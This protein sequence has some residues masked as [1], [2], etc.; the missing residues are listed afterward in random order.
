ML[1]TR[2]ITLCLGWLCLA[3]A[4]LLSAQQSEP[5]A[6][7]AANTFADALPDA[8]V[9]QTALPPSQIA[10]STAT[11]APLPYASLSS[12]TIFTNK[13]A[14]PLLG[15]DKLKYAGVEMI[16]PINLPHALVS[17]EFS[18]FQGGDP[19]YGN[20]FGAYEERFGAAMLRETS[21]RFF[22]DG[23]FP[24]M[25]HED[26]RYYR[27]DNHGTVRQRLLYSM[28]R[29]FVT[30]TDA[31]AAVPNYASLLG[32]AAGA[33]LTLSYYPG[34][35]Q[36][37]GVVLRTFADSIAVQIGLDMVREFAPKLRWLL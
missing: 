22:A 3:I 35:S 11:P 21:Y 19:K 7:T 8:P 2:R 32:H 37:G 10:A 28:T 6:R 36:G 27:M 1:G 5:H 17:A 34:T 18:Q 31:G 13:Q 23:L 15:I 25:L 33:A 26:P 20:D 14:R 29:S 12:R 24:L 4:P 9:P 30:R 16:R